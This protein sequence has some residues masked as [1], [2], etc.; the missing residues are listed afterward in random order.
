VH[1]HAAGESHRVRA[2]EVPEAR[3]AGNLLAGGT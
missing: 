2:L 3:H 1:A